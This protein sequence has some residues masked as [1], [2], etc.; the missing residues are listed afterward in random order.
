[1]KR[2]IPIYFLLAL[3][4]ILSTSGCTASTTP[5]SN[6]PVSSPSAPAELESDLRNEF[7]QIADASCQKARDIGVTERGADGT[8]TRLVLVPETFLYKDFF[9]AVI[10]DTGGQEPIWTVEDF[11]SCLDSVN[12]LMAEEVGAEYEISVSGNQ[13]DGLI[14]S[15]YVVDDLLVV[16]RDYLV[17][18]GVFVE[19]VVTSPDSSTKILI[20]YGTPAEQDIVYFREAID[21]WLAGS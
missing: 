20:D 17:R 10:S 8:T 15:E 14:R 19:V 6:L 11:I 5:S 18:N 12:F 2:S 16:T 13:A 1:M 9:A 3:F 21:L 7:R 4:A